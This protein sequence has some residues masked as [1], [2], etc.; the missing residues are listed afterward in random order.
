VGGYAEYGDCQGK[1]VTSDDIAP[2]Y[3]SARCARGFANAY[4]EGWSG[5]EPRGR[6]CKG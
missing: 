5:R 2:D 6:Q 1:C 3:M 4:G